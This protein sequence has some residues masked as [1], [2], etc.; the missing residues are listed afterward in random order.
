MRA[1]VAQAPRIAQPAGM[2]R[3]C[4]ADDIATVSALCRDLGLGDVTPLPLKAAHHTTLAIPSL[5]MVARVQSAEP[6][7]EAWQRAVDEIAVARHLARRSA[8]AIAPFGEWAGPHVADTSVVTFW[9]YFEARPAEEH[10][11]MHVAASLGAL[12]DALSDY[13]CPLPPYTAALDR[14]WSVLVGERGSGGLA[15]DDRALLMRHHRRLRGEAE[16]RASPWVPLHGDVHLGN[17]LVGSSSALWIDFEDACR[18]P[19]EYD[20]AGLPPETWSHFANTDLALVAVFADLRS[21][22][23]AIWCLVDYA[24]NAE[25]REAAAYHLG[26]IKGWA[27]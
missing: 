24:R 19:R 4:I 14:C 27:D 1:A 16:K 9:P 3:P 13:V 21:V 22:S 25:I 5:A 15:E 8:P 26:R 11:A 12:H 17:F 6:V 18:G 20:I 7:D 2:A 10:D 23:V